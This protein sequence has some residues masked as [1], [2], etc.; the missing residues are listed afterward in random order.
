MERQIV[1]LHTRSRPSQQVTRDFAT[2]RAVGVL[3]S[4]EN[5]RKYEL[6]VHV[7]GYPGSHR[8]SRVIPASETSA[9]RECIDFNPY[10]SLRFMKSWNICVGF[11]NFILKWKCFNMQKNNHRF[12]H[13]GFSSVVLE[14]CCSVVFVFFFFLYLFC[15]VL[16]ICFSLCWFGVFCVC[17]CGFFV[18]L[19][20]GFACLLVFPGKH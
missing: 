9:L 15:F 2:L 6:L 18:L 10:L 4:W 19:P 12:W 7:I 17:T 20:F 11:L 14:V 16:F 5:R 13:M 1:I 8:A 3:K